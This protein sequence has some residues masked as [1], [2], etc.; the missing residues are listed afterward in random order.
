MN[1]NKPFEGYFE[2]SLAVDHSVING[3]ETLTK[4]TPAVKPWKVDDSFWARV[5]END[6]NNTANQYTIIDLSMCIQRPVTETH[7]F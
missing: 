2:N 1:V 3:Y 5:L 6:W 7:D 4:Y